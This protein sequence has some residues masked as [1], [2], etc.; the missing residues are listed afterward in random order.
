M[1]DGMELIDAMVDQAFQDQEAGRAA[2]GGAPLDESLASDDWGD[3]EL[4]LPDASEEAARARGSR[5]A[6]GPGAPGRGF[7]FR[8]RLGVAPHPQIPPRGCQS[9]R[10]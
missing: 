5:P 6:P 10:F 1:A 4:L 2:A 7:K 8:N 9:T 3:G